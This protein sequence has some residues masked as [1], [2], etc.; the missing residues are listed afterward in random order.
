MKKKKFELDLSTEEKRKEL[1]NLFDSFRLKKEIFTYFGMT[2][3]TSNWEYIKNICSE[4]GFDWN[5]YNTRKKKYEVRHCLNCGKKIETGDSRKKFCDSSCAASYNNKQRRNYKGL[6]VR[7]EN[8]LLEA[9][10]KIDETIITEKRETNGN[11]KNIGERGERITIGE[12]AKFDIDVMLPM[13]DNLPFDLVVYHNNKFF[14]CQVK[15]TASKTV[16][17]SLSFNIESNDWHAKT[18]HQYTNEEVDVFILCD[19][20]NVYL[21]KF[22]EMNNK[23]SFILRNSIPCNKQTKGINFASDYIISDK[24]IEEVFS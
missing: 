16:N 13:S 17:N 19:L 4:I 22:K 3:N 8:E 24:R 18:T 5:V 21:V 10:K 2:K 9:V 12:L 23:R 1:Y 15:T 20:T 6:N 11:N 7:R 14:K